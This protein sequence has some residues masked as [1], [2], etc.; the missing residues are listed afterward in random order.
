MAGHRLSSWL[1][2]L[3]V[4]LLAC[5]ALPAASADAAQDRHW[6]EEHHKLALRYRVRALT[7]EQRTLEQLRDLQQLARRLCSDLQA[8]ER[9]AKQVE[10]IVAE[11]QA[12]KCHPSRCSQL[13]AQL[14]KAIKDEEALIACTLKAIQAADEA[15]KQAEGEAAE[16]LKRIKAV[17]CDIDALL[18][19]IERARACDAAGADALRAEIVALSAKIAKELDA[20]ECEMEVLEKAIAAIGRLLHDIDQQLRALLAGLGDIERAV[21]ELQCYCKKQA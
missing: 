8:V 6:L 3:A 21:A 4:L 16:Q 7:L 18:Q 20:I 1:V 2:V 5:C 11:L 12:S 13:E 14:L 10:C 9:I 15:I 17:E 19:L